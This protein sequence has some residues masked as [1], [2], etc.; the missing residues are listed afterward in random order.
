MAQF[1]ICIPP[2]LAH[3]F[4]T[5]A[6]IERAGSLPVFLILI[7]DSELNFLLLSTTAS[8][9]NSG[10]NANHAAY[11]DRKLAM[12]VIPIHFSSN[13]DNC[14]IVGSG[15]SVTFL[16]IPHKSLAKSLLALIDLVR[17]TS[18]QFLSVYTEYIPCNYRLCSSRRATCFGLRISHLPPLIVYLP[19]SSC[20]SLFHL[21]SNA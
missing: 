14:R 12:D 15:S 13:S 9:T 8:I 21:C 4:S 3:K 19:C 10:G 20:P 5:S 1:S 6:F 17:T 2:I 18:G 16:F 7:F 11:S